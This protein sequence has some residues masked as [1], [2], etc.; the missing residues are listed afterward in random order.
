MSSAVRTARGQCEA[1]QNKDVALYEARVLNVLV[2]NGWCAN[3]MY[4]ELGV[5]V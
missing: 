5:I 2:P 3:C 1:C 4:Y